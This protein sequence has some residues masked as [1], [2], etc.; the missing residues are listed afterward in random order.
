VARQRFHL[1]N[2]PGQLFASTIAQHLRDLLILFRPLEPQRHIADN[3]NVEHDPER[4]D[5][6]LR[7]PSGAN[8][9]VPDVPCG[10]TERS[11]RDRPEASGDFSDERYGDFSRDPAR[12]KLLPS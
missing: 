6:L 3:E 2:D 8:Y 10:A 7:G 11:P 4:P 1:L 12:A 5:L 9:V